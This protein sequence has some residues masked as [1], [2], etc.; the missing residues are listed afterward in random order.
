MSPTI[1][2]TGADQGL[3]LA[4]AKRFSKAG[5]TVFAGQYMLG[6]KDLANLRPETGTL[7]A[8]PLDVTLDASV[9][10]AFEKVAGLAS[11]LDILI[12]NAAIHP[13]A[14]NNELP[15]VD[16]DTMVETFAVNTIGP[17]RVAKQFL[18]LLLQGEKKLLINISSEAGSI[19]DCRRK[20]E[21]DYC[22][23][24]AALN[25]QSKILQNY[26]MDQGIKVLAV[27]PGWMRTAMGG[28]DADIS[29]EE[30]A[31]AI[32]NLADDPPGMEEP[33]YWDY[34]RQPL[35]W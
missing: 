27:H 9:E 23:S 35:R 14:S 26:L 20:A 13:Q 17:L 18:P 30:A 1:L 33:I 29:A 5:F 25:M 24:K 16:F 4:L 8:V 31:E 32:F 22:M 10:T 2:I 12:N 15:E 6:S 28:P 19:A 11:S 21:Y 34:R 7:H 3:G